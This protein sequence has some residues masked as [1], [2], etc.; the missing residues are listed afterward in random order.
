MP[1]GG[2]GMKAI[3]FVAIVILLGAVLLGL[4]LSQAD[5]FNQYTRTAEARRMDVETD[6]LAAQY[7]IDQQLRQI[8]L[9]R[10]QEETNINLEAL[11][12]RRAKELILMERDAQLKAELL[13]LAA[14]I[15]LWVLAALVG[16]AAFYLLC[17]GL[18]LLRRG[19]QPATEVTR[20]HRRVAPFPGLLERTRVSTKGLTTALALLVLGAAVFT[21]SASLL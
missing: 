13:E 8:E 10:I 14:R 4:N 12:A 18:V 9:A 5:V 21:V 20:E 7:E 6:A 19:K 3:A 17:A 1:G 16:A 2:N 11:R 15:S